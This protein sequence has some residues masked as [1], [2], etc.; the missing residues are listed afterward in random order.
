MNWD[1]ILSWI[2]MTRTFAPST[3]RKLVSQA[4]GDL[5]DLEAEK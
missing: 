5:R 2:R 4:R 1:E 3:L